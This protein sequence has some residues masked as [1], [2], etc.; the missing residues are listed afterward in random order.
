MRVPARITA[1][2]LTAMFLLAPCAS[3]TAIADSTTPT[4][5]PTSLPVA[6]VVPA[7][8]PPPSPYYVVRPH[9]TIGSVAARYDIPWRRLA[10]WNQL[11]APYTL[12]VDGVLRLD[13]PT[14]PLAPFSSTIIKPHLADTHWRAGCPVAFTDLRLVWVTYIDFNGISHKGYVVVHYSVA[15]NIQQVF[16]KLYDARFRIQAMTPLAVNT[17]GLTSESRATLAYNCR[18]MPTGSSYSQHAFGT[19][20]DINPGQN[21]EVTAAG[22]VHPTT[23]VTFTDR[24]RYRL[25]LMHPGGVVV[26]ALAAGGFK[27]GGNWHSSKD[28]MHFSVSGG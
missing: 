20:I 1:V 9:D 24:T 3:S 11:P 12:Q 7:V 2:W 21:P 17:P 26:R 5:V 23:A 19:A 4:A 18:L 15:R 8:P 28:Y 22:D 27:W 14:V 16:R 6:P 10:R 25:G 13:A